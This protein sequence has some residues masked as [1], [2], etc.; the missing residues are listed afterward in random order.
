M[1]CF[2]LKNLSFAYPEEREN[3]FENIS[4]TITDGEFVTLCGPSGCGKSTLLRHLKPVLTPHGNRSGEI[5]FK[6]IPLSDL[7]ARTQS[8]RIGFVQQSP[9]NQIVTDKVWH[10]LAFGLESLGCDTQTIRR[11]VSE[12]A[13]FFGIQSWFYKNVTEL[14]GGQKQL[15]NLASVMAMQPSVLILDEPTSQL[16]PIAASDFLA[17]V[18]RINRELGTT[19]IMTEH[20]LEDTFPLSTRVLVMDKNHIICDGRPEQV[21]EKLKASGHSMFLAMPA[22]MRVYAAVESKG[23]CPVTVRD[24]RSWLDFFAKEH[25]LL[26][27]PEEP[28]YD[29]AGKTPAIELKEAWF[30]YEKNAP[31]IVKGVTL[32]AYPGEFLAILGG[33]GTGKTTTLS[34]LSGL[35]RPY[36]GEVRINGVQGSG[37]KDLYQNLLGVLP[38]NPQS[39]FV[40]NT[41]WEDLTEML[42]RSALTKPARELRIHSVAALC[43]LIGLLDRHPYD[44]SGGE[45][46]RLALAKIL[47][48][49][50]KILLLD[51]PTKGLDGEFKQVLAAILNDLLSHGVTVVMVSHD[52]EFC[53]RYAH[54]CAFFFDG[55]V[56][57]DAPP[58][59]FF[60]CNSFYTTA[61]NR[62]AR[63]LVP[64]AVTVEDLIA[65]CGGV[66]PDEAIIDL[67]FGGDST[68]KEAYFEERE[69]SDVSPVR[70][71][72][73]LP[74]WRRIVAIISAIVAAVC[75]VLALRITD[76]S[77]VISAETM[78]VTSPTPARIA[79][80]LM[81]SLFV[82]ALALW[83]K[84]DA[85][86][87]MEQMPVE[88]RKLS[89]RTLAA[90]AL[91]LVA[92]PLTIYIGVYFL[93]DRKYYFISLLILLETMLPF[94]MV[95]ESR[96]PQ[97]RELVII[98]TLCAIAV[99]G[100]AAFFMLPQFKP[101]IALV[102]IS[103]VAFGGEAGFL[104][105]AMTMLLSNMLFTQGPWTP[106]QMFAAGIIG[107]LAGVLFQKGFLRRNTVSLCIFGA[108][109][110][111]IVYGVIMD[112]S[113]VIIWQPT[114]TLPMFI[115]S[116]VSGFAMNL[117]H[118]V[119]TVIFLMLF[120][121]P[122]LEKLDR[123]KVK[124]GLM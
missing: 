96:K 71:K 100:R 74:L 116:Y 57:S 103:G 4:L 44:L 97:A 106:W 38:Q 25:T 37:T 67:G 95:F 73:G 87:A 112:T 60:A 18:G 20:R 66:Q 55:T 86:M 10:E 113:S 110:T 8:E 31:D 36:R 68:G 122:M 123:I 17:T 72:R 54:R 98:A 35:N 11:R 23:V 85:P 33:N 14:S 121:R 24:G 29:Y 30:K 7:S 88:K 82:M 76:L 69:K 64:G 104:V 9:E 58:R 93:G 49:N 45:Q 41:V 102:I 43:R 89:K 27:L 34:L 12:M 28:G 15:L 52:V 42:A 108:I 78:S 2:E 124:Y 21:G 22:P 13:S 51:E 119:A 81:L 101:V 3:V 99:A 19:I 62:M 40:K 105:G 75:F 59:E 56:V 91:I 39:L 114:V 111:L 50:P 70:Q 90:S 80:P 117:V 32:A 77:A 120:A 48:L 16:D 63:H 65:V 118:T 5:L 83:Q 46:Q 94:A 61:C 84:S 115:A 109:T 92:I 79:L 26:P 47:L 53:A 6:G 107:F 1:E